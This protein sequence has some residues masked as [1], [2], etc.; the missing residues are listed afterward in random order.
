MNFILFYFKIIYIYF[1]HASSFRN[2]LNRNKQSSIN[3]E[4][5]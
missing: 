3:I 2:E 5:K 1:V 4:Y